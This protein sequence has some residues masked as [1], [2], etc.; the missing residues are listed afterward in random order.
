VKKEYS[1]ISDFLQYACMNKS[2]VLNTLSFRIVRVVLKNQ[3]K[4]KKIKQQ[5]QQQQQQQNPIHLTHRTSI[6]LNRSNFI[7]TSSISKS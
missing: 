7:V 2:F 6:Y 1:L 3:N 5:Q 4:T